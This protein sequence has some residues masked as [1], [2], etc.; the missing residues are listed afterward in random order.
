MGNPDEYVCV[1]VRSE[2]AAAEVITYVAGR[3]TMEKAENES[4][5]LGGESGYQVH[6]FKIRG[7]RVR[8]RT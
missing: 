4:V 2:M 8:K 1:V 3:I 6:R 7:S 5:C